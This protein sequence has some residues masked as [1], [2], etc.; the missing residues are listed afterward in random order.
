MA[1]VMAFVMAFRTFIGGRG[2][3]ESAGARA[4]A[5]GIVVAKLD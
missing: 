2:A 4:R 3:S 5:D 1:F